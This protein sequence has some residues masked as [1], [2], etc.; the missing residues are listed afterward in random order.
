MAG[1]YKTM[2]LIEEGELD[3]LR[4]RQLKDYNP[5]LKSLVNIQDQIESIINDPSHDDE[6]KHKILCH[7]Q[8][9]F[10]YLY[11]K[12]QNS[13]ANIVAPIAPIIPVAPIEEIN[14]GFEN[15]NEEEGNPEGIDQGA[16]FDDDLFPLLKL[17]NTYRKKFQ[18]FKDFL[19]QHR[20]QISSNQQNEL[21]LEGRPIPN[22][23]MSDLLRSFYLRNQNMNLIGLENLL[24]K[25]RA[26]KV[27]PHFFSHRDAKHALKILKKK[28]SQKGKGKSKFLQGPPG[29]KPRFLRV[30]RF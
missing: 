21:I 29:K 24:A 16:D 14:E 18:L 26:L 7:L 10:G 6:S 17:P 11:K 30:F 20:E 25:L 15:D 8:E 19:A 4:Q 1:K 5:G 22:S 27:S 12:F 2:T 28:E 13:S 3:R 23:S 9:K